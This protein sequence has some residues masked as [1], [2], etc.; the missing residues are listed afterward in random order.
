MEFL[1]PEGEGP[2]PPQFAG[3]LMACAGM[4]AGSLWGGGAAAN[5]RRPRA[6]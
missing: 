2:I 4:V 6:G 3:F 5:L 1:L